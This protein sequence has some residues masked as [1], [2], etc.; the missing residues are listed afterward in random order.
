MVFDYIAISEEKVSTNQGFKS[1]IPNKGYGKYYIYYLLKKYTEAIASQGTGTT[2]KEV[3]KDTFSEYKIGIPPIQLVD[4]YEKEV[5]KYCELR[6]NCEKENRELKAYR[7]YLLPML[8]T[9]QIKIKVIKN[10]V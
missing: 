9:G 8:M 6:L 4:L 3:S 7:D 2:F 10:T 1:I 5:G